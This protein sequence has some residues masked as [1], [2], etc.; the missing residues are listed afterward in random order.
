MASEAF[1]QGEST[2]VKLGVED[3][4]E[5]LLASFQVK[6]ERKKPFGLMQPLLVPQW[7]WEYITMDFVYKLPRTK[8]GYDGIW[9]VYNNSYHSSIGMSFFEALYGKSCRTPLCWSEVDERVLVDPEIVDETTHNIQNLA[10]AAVADARI[11]RTIGEIV[12]SHIGET[13]PETMPP[14]REP[15]SSANSSFPDIAQ[16]GEAIANAIQSLLRSPKKTHLETMYNLKM[17]KFMAGGS[18]WYPGGQSQ[19]MEF[20]SNSAGPLRQPSQPS[21]GHNAQGCVIPDSTQMSLPKPV[22]PNYFQFDM[23]SNVNAN[24]CD[25]LRGCVEL[26]WIHRL[27]CLQHHLLLFVCLRWHCHSGVPSNFFHFL[28]EIGAIG[29]AFVAGF[30]GVAQLDLALVVRLVLG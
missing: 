2:G 23:Q 6:A 22:F 21:Q 24:S 10:I 4:E 25:L 19:H 12:V 27:R 15:R 26:Q 16:L 28:V 7:K 5:A 17:D 13:F 8:N 3:R 14:R 29:T 18:Q 11:W 30:C 9:F 20:A 1:S